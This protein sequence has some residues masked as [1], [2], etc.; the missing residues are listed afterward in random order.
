MPFKLQEWCDNLNFRLKITET[1]D[2]KLKS[3]LKEHINF[4]KIHPFSDGNGRT[5]RILIIDL[6]INN[7][8][9][10]VIIPKDEKGK[11]IL[12]LNNEDS[13]EFFKCGSEIQKIEN[14]RMKAFCE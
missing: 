11:Y 5:G 6:C 3:I 14:E 2:E 13:E 7:N 1:D 12:I 9:I 4:E 10:P 8:L